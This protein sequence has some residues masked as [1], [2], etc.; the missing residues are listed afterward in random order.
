MFYEG[1]SRSNSNKPKVVYQCTYPGCRI[2]AVK[3]IRAIEAHV[4]KEH[5]G[6]AE[7]H[8]DD[9]EEEFYYTEVEIP[10]VMPRTRAYTEPASQMANLSLADHLDMARPAHEDPEITTAVSGFRNKM[11]SLS[12]T[13]AAAMSMASANGNSKSGSLLINQFQGSPASLTTPI[14][15][16]PSVGS[17]GKYILISPPGENV[18][19][20]APTNGSS[21]LKSPGHRRIREGKKCRKVYGLEQRD[22]WCTQCKWKKACA[23]FGKPSASSQNNAANNAETSSTSLLIPAHSQNNAVRAIK[24]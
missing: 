13:H 23:R 4:R 8:P 22:L 15:I 17:P 14:T 24:F 7:N 2:A 5:L 18:S 11:R 3:S 10:N 20:S 6:R 16:A 21:M 12:G 9:G 19:S 1:R